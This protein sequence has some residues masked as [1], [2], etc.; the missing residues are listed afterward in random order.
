MW[1]FTCVNG[2]GRHLAFSMSVWKPL[3]RNGPIFLPAF[4]ETQHKW[5]VRSLVCRFNQCPIPF[6]WGCN[7][8][9][10]FCIL[11]SPSSWTKPDVAD[12][13][14][15][16]SPHSERG[17]TGNSACFDLKFRRSHWCWK[18]PRSRFSSKSYLYKNWI[19]A[20][21]KLKADSSHQTGCSPGLPIPALQLWESCS[22]GPVSL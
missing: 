16:A 6:M 4:S 10:G 17:W 20:S 3:F 1:V 15:E 19:S 9:S 12:L 7:S 11:H 18:M 2:K 14:F 5:G 8:Q 13:E 22:E 21:T